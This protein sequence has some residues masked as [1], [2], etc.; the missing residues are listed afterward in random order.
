[1]TWKQ[2]TRGNSELCYLQVGF[3]FVTALWTGMA[4]GCEPLSPNVASSNPVIKHFFFFYIKHIPNL[5]PYLNHLE[6]MPN[7]KVLELMPTFNHNLKN[8][9]LIR[10]LNFKH[11]VLTFDI[12]K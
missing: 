9:E 4:E 8:V 11:S 12:L 2:A 1:M 10:K 6:L 3:G 5:N 7:L